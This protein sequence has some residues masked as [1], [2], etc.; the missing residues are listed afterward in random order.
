MSLFIKRGLSSTGMRQ[1]QS[2]RTRT[3]VSKRRRHNGLHEVYS[4][5]TTACFQ[6]GK[7]RHRCERK[8]QSTANKANICNSSD[9][10]LRFFDGVDVTLSCSISSANVS[11]VEVRSRLRR[12][13]F[14]FVG[15]F[16]SVD[17]AASLSTSPF[18]TMISLE[19]TASFDATAFLTDAL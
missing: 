19:P 12:F 1:W 6:Y 14:F 16:P 2:D 3:G 10:Y 7:Q 18:I 9:I 5:R 4:K 8:T 11:L 17:S 15:F 13:F